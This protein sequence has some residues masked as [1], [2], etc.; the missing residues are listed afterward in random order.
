MDE[1]ARGAEGCEIQRC[2][3]GELGDGVSASVS[4]HSSTRSESDDRDDR[5]SE[6][7][8][9]NAYGENGWTSEWSERIGGDESRSDCVQTGG[10][11]PES[12]NPP[13]LDLD[14]D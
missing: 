7:N 3:Y 4:S 11:T 13:L 12:L 9:P 6:G 5:R 1:S 2:H 14:L 10:R 8:G